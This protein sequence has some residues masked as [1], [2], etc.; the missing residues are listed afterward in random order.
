MQPVTSVYV[1]CNPEDTL[2]K[3][4]TIPSRDNVGKYAS[5]LLNLCNSSMYTYLKL[6]TSFEI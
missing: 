6:N 4:V 5:Y 1:I 3:A 2:Q